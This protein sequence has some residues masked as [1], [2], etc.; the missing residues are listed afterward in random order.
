MA[1]YANT[2]A[3]QPEGPAP[4]FQITDWCVFVRGGPDGA[5]VLDVDRASCAVQTHCENGEEPE[6][7]VA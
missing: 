7:V 2:R 1:S 4:I 5:G 6:D 3:G